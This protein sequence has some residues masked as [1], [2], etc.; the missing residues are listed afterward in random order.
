MLEHN[1]KELSKKNVSNQK[2]IRM[3]TERTKGQE[4]VLADYEM[5]EDAIQEMIAELEV[6][7]QQ[8]KAQ[9][10]GSR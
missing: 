10:W 3:L 4:A 7:R 2:I 5:R 8:T 6:L 1:E 9:R